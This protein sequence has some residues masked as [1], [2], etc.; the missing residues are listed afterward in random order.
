MWEKQSIQL[1]CET[2]QHQ[3]TVFFVNNSFSFVALSVESWLTELVILGRTGN[4][5][6]H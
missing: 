3:T 6:L 2:S 1:N 4:E 5:N